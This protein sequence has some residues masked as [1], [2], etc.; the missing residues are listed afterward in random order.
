MVFSDVD[1]GAHE[2][3]IELL[4]L[5][6]IRSRFDVDHAHVVAAIREHGLDPICD[7]RCLSLAG[8]LQHKERRHAISVRSLRMKSYY[9]SK[10]LNNNI[11]TKIRFRLQLTALQSR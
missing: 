8:P 2:N 7:L 4:D 1:R 10:S 6:R 9:Q 3:G 5:E 11:V